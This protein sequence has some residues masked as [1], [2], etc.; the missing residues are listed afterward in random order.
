[1]IQCLRFACSELRSS[2]I[3]FVYAG[4]GGV[5]K[6][7]ITYSIIFRKKIRMDENIRFQMQ[8]EKVNLNIPNP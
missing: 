8:F 1:M 7:D 5:E 2:R 6:N 4:F 3:A